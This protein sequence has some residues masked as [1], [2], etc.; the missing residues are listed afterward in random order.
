VPPN[1]THSRA[2]LVAIVAAVAVV[3]VAAGGCWLVGDFSNAPHAIA[4][5]DGAS[6]DLDTEWFRADVPGPGSTTLGLVRTDAADAPTVVVFTSSNGLDRGTESFVARLADHGVNAVVACWFVSIGTEDQ[7]ECEDGPP[8]R[9][10]TDD[11]LGLA[12]SIVDSVRQLP[13]IDPDTI[14]VAGMSRG[15]G[16]AV[17]RSLEGRPE[18]AI[19]VN[20]LL[21]GSDDPHGV[22]Y[23][24]KNKPDEVVLAERVDGYHGALLLLWSENDGVVDPQLNGIPLVAAILE[25][26]PDREPPVVATQPI[27]GH[28]GLQGGTPYGDP[29][30]PDWT[31]EQIVTFVRD[32]FST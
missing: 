8:M 26:H 19:S 6:E 22:A 28:G 23:E 16:V 2:S 25:A 20:G 17:L 1:R 12:D 30:L 18:P 32:Q 31:A 11:V 3:A 21:G 10:V 14:A 27:G 13:G 15:G 24:P 29:T 9:W 7:I 4:A 5:P